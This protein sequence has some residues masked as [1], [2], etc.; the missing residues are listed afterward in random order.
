MS[1]LNL[2]LGLAIAATIMLVV[3]IGSSGNAKASNCSFS[4]SA[5]HGSLSSHASFT[6]PGSCSIGAATSQTIRIAHGTGGFKSSCAS[7][8]ASQ[9]H[10]S[11]ETDSQDSGVHC[12]FP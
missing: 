5:A 2:A 7:N 4:S 8:F 12:P 6:A 3:P 10:A 1:K 9:T 11:G